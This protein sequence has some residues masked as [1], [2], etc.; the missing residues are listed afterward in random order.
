MFSGAILIHVFS[1]LD[2]NKYKKAKQNQS[3]EHSNESKAHQNDESIMS[4]KE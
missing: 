1:Q 4:S 3:F 2:A